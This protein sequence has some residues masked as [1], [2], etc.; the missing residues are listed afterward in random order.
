MIPKNG[1]AFRVFHRQKMTV[2]K[3]QPMETPDLM[4]ERWRIAAQG[5]CAFVFCWPAGEAWGFS[6]ASERMIQSG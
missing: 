2:M 6:V 4:R 5:R 3:K 1:L